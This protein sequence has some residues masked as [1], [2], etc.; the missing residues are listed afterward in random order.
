MV[1]THQISFLG[2]QKEINKKILII[3]S[4]G[5]YLNFAS[6]WYAISGRPLTVKVHKRKRVRKR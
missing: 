5:H 1:Q 3:Y 4:Y 6:N 2:L